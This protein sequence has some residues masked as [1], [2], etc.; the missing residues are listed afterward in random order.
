M[1]EFIPTLQGFEMSFFLKDDCCS[2]RYEPLREKGFE[3]ALVILDCKVIRILKVDGDGDEQS[4]SEMR[5]NMTYFLTYSMEQ[6]PS[7]K[8]DWF[9]ASQEIP[10]RFMEPE[11]FPPHSQ[12]PATYP[13]PEP[14]QSSP[15]AHIPLLED[16]S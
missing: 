1:R 16:P 5:Q 2:L 4:H 15:H 10:P 11:G 12:A 14:A 7:S 9:A 8:A 6:S 3:Y 13:Y